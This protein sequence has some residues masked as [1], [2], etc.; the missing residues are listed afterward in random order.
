MSTVGE[1]EIRTQ[2]R[3]V[4][5]FRDALG[6]VYL[7]NRKDRSDNR[8]VEKDRVADRLKRQGYRDKIIGKVLFEPNKA[9]TLGSNKNLY[10]ASCEVYGLPRYGVTETPEKYWLHWK[11]ADTRPAPSSRA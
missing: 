7:G 4:K 2:Q 10:D 8:N 6:Y 5:F 9:T 3:V 11:E 1:R